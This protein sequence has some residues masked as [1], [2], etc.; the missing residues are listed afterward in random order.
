[1]QETFCSWLRSLAEKEGCNRSQQA[2]AVLLASTV[3]LPFFASTS[4]PAKWAQLQQ[5][6]I[7]GRTALPK[8]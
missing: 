2:G 3:P 1:M 8:W 5:P 6:Y 7:A 4:P